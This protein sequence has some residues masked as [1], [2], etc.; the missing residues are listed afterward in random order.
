MSRILKSHHQVLERAWSIEVVRGSI[1]S[2]SSFTTTTNSA[3]PSHWL[4][5]KSSTIPTVDPPS[6]SLLDKWFSQ[7]DQNIITSPSR[8]LS[9]LVA[10][11]L[12]EDIEPTATAEMSKNATKSDH[13]SRPGTDRTHSKSTYQNMPM[14]LGPASR[15][16]SWEKQLEPPSP[17]D[18]RGIGAFADATS[19]RWVI[20]STMSPSSSPKNTHFSF[21][22][23]P[24]DR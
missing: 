5:D 8:S 16:A 13:R 17:L 6:D 4:H 9:N 10:F 12:S 24:T 18:L 3:P 2:T 1:D 22:V 11:V 7:L 19:T 21:V 20:P 23:Q 15:S 14:A